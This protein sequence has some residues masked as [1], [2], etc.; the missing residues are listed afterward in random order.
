MACADGIEAESYRAVEYRRELD[1]L[2]TPQA[3]IGRP[4]MRVL[5]HEVLDNVGVEPLGHVPYVKRNANDVGGTAG[6]AGVFQR[7]AA[8][9]ARPVRAGVAGQGEMHAGD[10]VPGRGRPSGGNCR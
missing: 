2:V 7:A 10:V 3:G 5:T 9:R 6:I 4:A 1:L 8:A